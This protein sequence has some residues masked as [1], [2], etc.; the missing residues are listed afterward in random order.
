MSKAKDKNKIEEVKGA[1]T[2]VSA[3]TPADETVDENTANAVVMPPVEDKA[4]DLPEDR[5]ES[6]A[7]PE[8]IPEGVV[9]VKAVIRPMHSPDDGL[10][11]P[12]EGSVLI[13]E[14]SWAT[15]Q[16]KRGLLKIVE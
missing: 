1:S 6:P 5:E 11:I 2:D 3:D 14:S 10:T 16:I 9:R 8:E 15:S 4:E 7:E 13:K 12:D